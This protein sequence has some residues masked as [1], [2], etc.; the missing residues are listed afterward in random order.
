[1]RGILETDLAREI[2]DVVTPDDQ[3]AVLAIDV[4]QARLRRHHSIKPAWGS[5]VRGH[6]TLL[7][8]SQFQTE[9][10]FTACDADRA[11]QA[12]VPQRRALRQ[13]DFIHGRNSTPVN[14]G[15]SGH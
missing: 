15:K 4:A 5:G 10:L 12:R 1:M 6:S 9:F 2:F 7:R 8:I 11:G 3:N 14:R 13:A